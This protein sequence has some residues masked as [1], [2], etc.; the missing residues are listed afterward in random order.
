VWIGAE[1]GS[2]KIL[3]AMDR[4]VQ[5]SQVQQMIQVANQKGLET[6]TFIMLGYPGETEADIRA[7][8]NHLRLA[9]PKH[10][11]I[12][13]AYPIKGTGLYQEVKNKMVEKLDWFSSTDRDIDFERHYPRSYYDYALRWVSNGVYF[14]QQKK[15]ATFNMATLKFG[16]KM[17]IARLG[18]LWHRTGDQ[19][20]VSRKGRKDIHAKV[21]K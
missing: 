13:L 14:Y 8:L 9:N 11:T 15:K 4:R 5:S 2:Q 12:T 21:A 16:I 1:S 19:R 3:N 10:F 18:M 17:G 20:F 6:G 7:T